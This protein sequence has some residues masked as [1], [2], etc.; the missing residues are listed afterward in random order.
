MDYDRRYYVEAKYSALVIQSWVRNKKNQ[1]LLREKLSELVEN[2]R[3]ENRLSKL[4]EQVH[5]LSP[6]ADVDVNITL[7]SKPVNEDMMQEVE[8][9]FDYLRR[10]ISEL[11]HENEDLKADTDVLDEEKR[12]LS[13]HV[14]S[15]HAATQVVQNQ[16]AQLQ[17]TNETLSAEAR[18]NKKKVTILK[19]ELKGLEEHHLQ[20]IDGMRE[21]YEKAI[22]D[23]DAEIRELKGELKA[24]E[25]ALRMEREMLTDEIERVQ[26]EHLS[27]IMRLKN[28]LKK[29]RDS[30]HDYLAKLMDGKYAGSDKNGVTKLN[31]LIGLPEIPWKMLVLYLYL[32]SY[33]MHT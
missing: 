25:T 10:E 1:R 30:H 18:A 13:L 31:C 19:K 5:V 2:A 12:E 17:A 4:Q 21:A 28:E 33:L 7:G 23:R 14:Q 27:E 22:A 9:M 8:T 16:L 26:E 11:R 6:E 20:D 32:A 24:S 29:T 3:M 15:A